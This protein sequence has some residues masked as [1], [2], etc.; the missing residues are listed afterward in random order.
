MSE[1]TENVLKYVKEN[2]GYR[3][4]E[5]GLGFGLSKETKA[6]QATDSGAGPWLSL[7]VNCCGLSPQ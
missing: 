1:L 6:D 7:L 2:I 3:E 5:N 4:K